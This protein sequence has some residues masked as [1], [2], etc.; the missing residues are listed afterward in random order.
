MVEKWNPHAFVRQDLFGFADVI[1]FRG[2]V[3][4]LVQCCA[5]AS[6]ADRV[7]KVAATPAAALW[8]VGSPHRE[9]VVQAWGKFGARG[10]RKKWEC[11][12]ERPFLGGGGA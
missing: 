1:A 9:V 11:R 6:K 5:V 8:A 7:R 4:L 2:Y 12:E 10:K 3:V